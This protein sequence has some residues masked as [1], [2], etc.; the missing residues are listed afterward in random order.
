MILRVRRAFTA[1]TREY[2]PGEFLVDPEFRNIKAM[3]SD[4][5][6]EVHYGPVP[7]VATSAPT[8]PKLSKPSRVKA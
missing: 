2:A 1:G 7:E 8:L 5:F 4:H 3:I 6:L